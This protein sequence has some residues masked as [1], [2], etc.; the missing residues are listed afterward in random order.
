MKRILIPLFILVSVTGTSQG[1]MQSMLKTYFRT[2]PFDM[3]FSSFILSFQRDPWFTT[4]VYERRTDTSLFYFSGS[5]KN[6]N[7]F[8]Y[9]PKEIRVI[10]AE[11]IMAHSDS[12]QTLDT[13]INY[14]LMGLT[15][16]G[17]EYQ[18][19]VE[20]E[21]RKFH[22]SKSRHFSESDHKNFQREGKIVAE[23]KNYFIFPFIIAPVTTAWGHLKETDQYVFT[24][25]IRFKIKQNIADLI[26]TP[27]GF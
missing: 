15:N 17:P 19:L 13:I 23:I 4:D 10:V 9:T 5:Y 16:P 3:K 11:E 25:T 26:V 24:I 8:T 2:H 18:K 6:F 27:L 12:L 14:Q 20:K 21:F 22:T 7:P 1:P